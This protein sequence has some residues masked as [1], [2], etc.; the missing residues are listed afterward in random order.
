MRCYAESALRSLCV[1][2]YIGLSACSRNQIIKICSPDTRAASI[3]SGFDF[4]GL[5]SAG[6]GKNVKILIVHG[7]GQDVPKNNEAL[8]SK[9]LVDGLVKTLRLRPG[10]CGGEQVVAKI[11]PVTPNPE[12]EN[13]GNNYGFIKQE[14][15]VSD[16]GACYTFYTLVWSTLSAPFKAHFLGFDFGHSEGRAK[17]N[18]AL[19]DSLIDHSI[20]DAVLFAGTFKDKVD[21][22]VREAVC[23]VVTGQ[24]CGGALYATGANDEVF[25]ISHSLGSRL[26][27]DALR[28]SDHHP[29]METFKDCLGGVFMLANQLPLLEL[30]DQTK[31]L[32]GEEANYATERTPGLEGVRNVIGRHRKGKSLQFIAFS[33]PNDLLSYAL[34][35]DWRKLLGPAS[36]EASTRVSFVNAFVRNHALDLGFVVNPLQAHVGYWDNPYVWDLIAHGAPDESRL[37]ACYPASK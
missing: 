30:S 8:Y 15:Y 31:S 24:K 34:P 21:Y 10:V 6:P 28:N 4:Q 1:I 22:S 2:T 36:D 17:V 19:K 16:G 18:Q 11:V 26:V 23:M 32:P 12:D 13:A 25:I 9:P 35:P 33:D 3:S 27:F 20:S 14:Y 5:D 7:I 37:Q 29:E